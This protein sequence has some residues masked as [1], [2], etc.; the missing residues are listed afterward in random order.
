MTA[1]Y[2]PTANR[3][4]SEFAALAFSDARELYDE[5]GKLLPIH[6]LPARV[7]ATIKK[8]RSKELK[9]VDLETGEEKVVGHL[10]EVEFHDKV[11]PLHL[12]GMHEN[13]FVE[14]V[15]LPVGIGFAEALREA[16]ARAQ[17]AIRAPAI[18]SEVR[19]LPKSV[20]AR[21]API[22]AE[23]RA[24]DAKTER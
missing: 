2:R 21:I 16:R 23:A 4:L 10:R 14:K 8:V 22:E 3:I 18:E 24:F 17:A 15:E 11:R 7:T 13:L 9:A 1:R 19:P 6:Q 5:N 20:V 12:L